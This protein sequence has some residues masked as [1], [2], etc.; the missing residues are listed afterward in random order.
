MGRLK[1][2]YPQIFRFG[3]TIGGDQFDRHCR[4]TAEFLSDAAVTAK[5]LAPSGLRSS[6]LEIAVLK[7]A[8]WQFEARHP[9][10]INA[11][12]VFVDSAGPSSRTRPVALSRR[13]RLGEGVLPRSARP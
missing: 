11:R 6:T 7:Q 12:K 10:N 8:G 13:S 1:S 3:E 5:I 4:S 9:A 2:D